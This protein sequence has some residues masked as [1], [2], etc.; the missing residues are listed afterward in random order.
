MGKQYRFISWQDMYVLPGH[1]ATVEQI[2]VDDAE[3]DPMTTITEKGPLI[4]PRPIEYVAQTEEQIQVL[5]EIAF[6]LQSGHM[7]LEVTHEDYHKTWLHLLYE[8][9]AVREVE[10]PEQQWQ[11]EE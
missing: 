9:Q 1:I 10:T 11:V 6:H 8:N 2:L 4:A 3:W 5:K 7:I